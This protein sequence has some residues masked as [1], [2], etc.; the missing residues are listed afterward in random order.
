MF[1]TTLHEDISWLGVRPA[2][3]IRVYTKADAIRVS[4]KKEESLPDSSS[5]SDV[6]L[7]D[8]KMV[9]RGCRGLLIINHYYDGM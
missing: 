6:A 8:G 5:N 7:V 9:E 4:T 2:A 3:L 1:W